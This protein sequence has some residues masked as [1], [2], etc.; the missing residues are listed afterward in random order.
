[1][2][3][4]PVE[5]TADLYGVTALDEDFTPINQYIKYVKYGFGRVT[6]YINEDLRNK[7]ISRQQGI[8]IIEKYDSSI[9]KIYLK[10]YCNYLDL[11]V[12]DF[13]KLY[14]K[15]VNK[16]LFTIKNKKIIPKFQVGVGLK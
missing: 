16:N 14:L 5:K 11:S 7:R 6:D 8:D 15:N 1:M 9:D 12:D 3:S 4:D 10:K 2:R 13:G